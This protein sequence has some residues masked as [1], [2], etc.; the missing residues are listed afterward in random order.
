MRKSSNQGFT[1]TELLCVLTIIGIL[2]AILLPTILRIIGNVRVSIATS[3]IALQGGASRID[4]MAEGGTPKTLCVGN[5]EGKIRYRSITGTDCEAV[6]D[7]QYIGGRV[8]IDLANSTLRSK[9]GVAGNSSSDD[10]IYRLAYAD[11]KAGIGASYGQLGRLTV[12]H[13]WT[14]NKKCIFLFGVD[15]RT[16][17]RENKQCNR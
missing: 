11:T 7:W 13:P 16:D 1:L 17:I 3:Q 12:I 5:F 15:G 10:R 2:S 4:A 8:Q 9:S 6:K 14:D